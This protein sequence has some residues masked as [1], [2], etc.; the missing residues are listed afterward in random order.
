MQGQI[1]YLINKGF[2]SV[3]DYFPILG[4]VKGSCGGLEFGSGS[5]M[6]SL[7]NTTHQITGA[8]LISPEGEK[9]L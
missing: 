5:A 1:P 7:Q 2:A 4:Q 8:Q 9:R 6:F 3:S